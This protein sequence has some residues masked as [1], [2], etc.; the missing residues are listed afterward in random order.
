VGCQISK[1]VQVQPDIQNVETPDWIAAGS[2]LLLFI[3]L[4]LPWVH[5]KWGGDL[6]GGKVTIN[7]GPSFGWISIF[8]VIVVFAIVGVTIFDVELPFP[9]GLVYLGAGGLSALFTLLVMLLRPIGTGGLTISGFSKIPW[10]G[11][12]IALIAGI[13]ILVAGFM[14]FQEQRY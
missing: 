4:F 9:S 3:S 8:S 14:K 10:Y 2:A 1:E 13:G 11:A 12:F 6:A 7:A 5:V